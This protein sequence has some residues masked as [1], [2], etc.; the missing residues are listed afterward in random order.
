[1]RLCKLRSQIEC[2]LTR[3]IGLPEILWRSVE[4]LIEKGAAVRDAAVSK[5]ITRIEFDRT[6]IQLERKLMRPS[7]VRLEELPSAKVVLVSI[8][9][10]RRDLL[11]RF[12]LI[13]REDNAQGRN[14]ARR[15]LILD[16]KNIFEL[17]VV[18]LRPEL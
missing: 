14:D 17:A 12:L 7:A 1:M 15:D 13:L 2:A 5:G 4:I 6:I 10:G 3:C 9:V 11:D 16:C 8:D 18:S